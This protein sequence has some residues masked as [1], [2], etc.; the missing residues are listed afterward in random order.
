[1][2]LILGRTK[3]RISTVGSINLAISFVLRKWKKTSHVALIIL[4]FFW[5]SRS[6]DV[7]SDLHFL[8]G[9]SRFA[10]N[11]AWMQSV[12]LEFTLVSRRCHGISNPEVGAILFLTKVSHLSAPFLSTATCGVLSMESRGEFLLHALMVALNPNKSAFSILF[13]W[14]VGDGLCFFNSYALDRLP[15]KAHLTTL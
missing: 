11:D 10:L 6:L 4:A 13:L 14:P 5:I 2:I 12:G 9:S 3:Y 8:F 7:R 1:M 15:A